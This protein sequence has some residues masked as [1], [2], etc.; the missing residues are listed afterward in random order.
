MQTHSCRRIA[1]PEHTSRRVISRVIAEHLERRTLLAAWTPYEQISH[2]YSGGNLSAAADIA[3]SPVTG[4]PYVVMQTKYTSG[5][6]YIIQFCKPVRRADGSLDWSGTRNNPIEATPRGAKL[7]GPAIA[8]GTENGQEQIDV[9]Y[10]HRQSMDVMFVQSTNGGQTWSAPVNLSN[11]AKAVNDTAIAADDQGNVYVAWSDYAGSGDANDLNIWF[12]KLNGATGQW[13]PKRQIE[14]NNNTKSSFVELFATPGSPNV[15]VAWGDRLASPPLLSYAMSAD[16]GATFTAPQPVFT[17]INGWDVRSATVTEAADGTVYA[18]AHLHDGSR[19]K[20]TFMAYKAPGSA[21]WSAMDSIDGTSPSADPHFT[22]DRSGRVYLSWIK[23]P[24]PDDGYDFFFRYQDGV[25]AHSFDAAPHF[26]VTGDGAKKDSGHVAVN[27]RATRPGFAFAAIESNP[28]GSHQVYA[29]TIDLRVAP[30]ADV[31][32]V[33]PDP[34]GAPVVNVTVS[35]TEAVT[36]V[37][38]ADFRLTRNGSPVTITGGSATTTNGGLSWVLSG[39]A[40]ETTPAGQYQLTLIAAGSGIASAATAK[41]MEADASDVWQVTAPATVLDRHVFYNNSAFDGNDPAFN[42]ADDAAIAPDKDPLLP[43]QTATFA[44][45]TSY[46]KGLNGVMIDVRSLPAG[47]TQLSRSQDFIFQVGNAGDPSTWPAAP[48]PS[49]ITGIRRGQGV[50]TSDRVTI[51]W[52]DSAIRGQWLR[53]TM[54]ATANTGLSVPDVFYFGNAVGE[55]GNS[56]SD[57]VVNGTDFA[58]A[59]DNQRGSQNLASIDWRWDYNR[60][61]LVNGTDLAIARDN[62]TGTS[63]ALRLITAPSGSA[64]VASA[65]NEANSGR[66]PS[67]RPVSATIFRARRRPGAGA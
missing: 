24:Y 43:G 45:Y 47:V 64:G 23:N 25:A 57:A 4:L 41:A 52:P 22:A 14:S 29:S 10:W 35:F 48:A 42:A 5:D 34:R 11:S 54:K 3:V 40:D 36:G 20:N 31:V 65:S 33:T 1:N 17:A 8:V 60:D 30:V 38:A 44:N 53:V 2:N 55:S 61:R 28:S 63:A 39:L 7:L 59:R 16:S 46:S 21:T 18:A 27:L 15:H 58:G 62:V 37:D 66:V 6:Q 49:P 13:E 12:R 50:S 56:G 32:D 67:T 26:Q 51:V 19:N 9:A